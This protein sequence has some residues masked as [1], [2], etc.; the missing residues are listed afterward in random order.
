M[1]KIVLDWNKYINSAVDCAKE[2]CVLLENNGVLPFNKGIRLSIFGRIASHYYKSGTGSGGMVNVDRVVSIIDALKEREDVGLNEDLLEIY[3][4]WEIQ[5]PFESG[6]GWGGEPWSQEEMPLEDSVVKSAADNSDAALVVIGRTA[7]EDKDSVDEGGSYRLTAL[8]EDMLAKTR[9]YFHKVVVILNVGQIIDMSFV[10]KYSPDAVMY[11]WHGGM[12]GGYAVAD[13]VMGDENPSGK[14][15]DTIAYTLADYPS[16]RYFGNHTK[17]YYSEDIYVGYRYFETFAKEKVR[18]PFGYG[19]SYTDF[20]I[21]CT[22]TDIVNNVIKLHIRVTNTGIYPGKEVVQMY[23]NAPDGKLATA[24]RVLV[25]FHK[26]PLLQPQESDNIILCAPFD[27]FT[28]YD[29]M[30]SAY[31]LLGGKYEVYVGSDVRSA[32]KCYDFTLEETI[33]KKVEQALAPV[34]TFERFT[35]APDKTL[36]FE[37]VITSR[38]DM[39]KRR[40]SQLPEDV[41]YTGDKGIKLKD[42][43]ENRHTMDEFA[44][45]LSNEELFSIVRGEGM[46]SSK[47]TPGTAAAFAGVTEQLKELGVPAVCCDDGPGGM[48][49]DSG[50]KAFAIPIGTLIAA[51]FNTELVS[52]LFDYVGQEMSYNNVECLLGPGMN[53]HRYPLNG[54]NFEY[55]SEDPFLTGKMA[56]AELEGL[57]KYNVTGTIKHFCGN[58][59]ESDR[60]HIDSVISERALREIYLKGF[61]IAVKEGKATTIMTTYG[62]LNGLWTAGSYDLNTTIL[63]NEWG[64]KGMVMT[65]WWAAINERG[66]K[67]SLTN[68]AA[69]IRAQN[70]IYM[71]TPDSGQNIH[72]DNLE[73]SLENGTLLHSELVRCAKNILYTAMHTRAMDRLMGTQY[74]VDIV[75][76][77]QNADDVDVTN[78]EFMKL[79]DEEVLDLTCKESVKGTAYV[80]AYENDTPGEYIFTLTG[81]SALGRL[82]QIP[83]TISFSGIPAATFTFNGSNGQDIG[84]EKKLVLPHR[85]TIIK[86]YVGENGVR[87][88][89]LKISKTST[90]ELKDWIKGTRD[91]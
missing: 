14:L 34:E 53:I 68:F 4:Q 5:H 64:F 86:V 74:Y 57:R 33:V 15:P 60:H 69:M 38:N 22:K 8:E 42:V 56:C 10:D 73:E 65:D 63:R 3:A 37:Q 67:E 27:R 16:H 2:G 70:D 80:Y 55:F 20:K 89:K 77:P 58:N 9:K 31:I 11:V 46:G 28:S 43:L 44:A 17:N 35:K 72:G 81:S 50:A 61:E 40:K 83:V 32:E 82:A 90:F 30:E 71:V 45:Q 66:K 13:I 48:R 1:K 54:R 62:S 51:T 85:F 84:V 41:L 75:N 7:G 91:N 25:A 24:D 76:R 19:K 12:V 29:E 59:Q 78:M 36:T 49:L 47:V 79:S 26:T 23:I 39:E 18:Y 6:M 87:L 52:S 88:K 21:E